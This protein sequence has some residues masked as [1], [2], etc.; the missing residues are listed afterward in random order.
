MATKQLKIGNQYRNLILRKES[1]DEESRTVELSFS[2]ETPVER[3]WG[4]EILGHA[5]GECDL[6]RLNNRG[7]FLMDHNRHDQRGVVENAWFDKSK[8]R[9]I[10]KISKSKRGDEL[11]QD[12]RDEIRPHISV[13]YRI[14]DLVHIKTVEG[15]DWYRAIKWMP[16]E[17]SSVSIGADETVGLGRNDE[18]DI[19]TF[20]IEVRESKMVEKVLEK[21]KEQ[22][23]LADETEN[24]ERSTE[25]R[26]SS[27][28]KI[29]QQEQ[30]RCNEILEIGSQFGLND[31]ARSAIQEN[32]TVDTFRKTV[33]E[34]V[35]NKTLKPMGTDLNLGLTTKEVR[36]Y[37][38]L[39]AVRASVT[40]NWKKAGFEREVSIALAEKQ[41]KDARGFFVNYE[42]LANLGRNLQSSKAGEGGELIAT[43]LWSNQFIDL[44][45]PQSIGAKLGVRFATGLVG[46]VDVPKM[47]SGAS[48]YWIDE[49]ENVTDS[50]AS[51]GVVKMSPKTVGGAVPITR[52]LMAQSTPDVDLLL[53]DHFLSG[54]GLVIDKAIFLGSG[55]GSEPRGITKTTGIHAVPFPSA[56]IDWKSIV[57]LETVISEA[58]ANAEA[59]AYIMRPSMRGKLKTTQVVNGQAK[60]LWENNS[61]NGYTGAVSTQLEANSILAGDFSQVL[62]G[63]WG[64][65]DLMLDKSAKAASGGAV[66]RVFQDADIAVRHAPAFA[67]CK[68]E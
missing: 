9:A 15:V 66:L 54:I 11:L 39:N 10:V 33:L 1:L 27:E 61:V 26:P 49:D 29:R 51:F 56:G 43:E 7:A 36:Q 42:V 47:S 28:I 63:L 14:I 62:V 40:G 4:M 24:N 21:A 19:R 44:L 3:Y 16:F 35:R 67:Y 6:S 46:N 32:M 58:N 22:K 38:L 52:R 37:S 17:I 34:S 65:I 23:R 2:S 55:V 50:S 48:F 64:A 68:A 59:M 25:P 12:M 31:Q 30:V 41:G 45:K 57:D 5:E 18:Q 13:G 60:F 20:N 8:G 53:R